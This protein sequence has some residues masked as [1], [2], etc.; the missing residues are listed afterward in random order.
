MDWQISGLILTIVL[1]V[2]LFSG[3]WIAI[4]FDQI[5]RT[6]LVWLRFRTGRWKGIAI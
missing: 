6:I 4:N 3:V 2:L 1:F 5:V